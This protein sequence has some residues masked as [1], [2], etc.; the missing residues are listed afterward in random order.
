M[1]GVG[2][3]RPGHIVDLLMRVV[4]IPF[5]NF[6]VNVNFF[7]LHFAFFVVNLDLL[8]IS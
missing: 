4:V 3:L 8:S 7:A 5:P 6:A 1:Y 2:H